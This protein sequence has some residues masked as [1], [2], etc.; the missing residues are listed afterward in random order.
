MPVNRFFLAFYLF[1]SY[2]KRKWIGIVVFHAT[3]KD[4]LFLHK[5]SAH[6]AKLY[7]HVYHYNE[8]EGNSSTR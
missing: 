4:T 7:L 2:T 3:G 5:G 6:S 8:N 1:L